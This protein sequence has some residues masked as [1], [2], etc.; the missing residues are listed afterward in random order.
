MSGVIFQR[1]LQSKNTEA[2]MNNQTEM[3][4]SIDAQS[5]IEKENTVVMDNPFGMASE[6]NS[7][8]EKVN[9]NYRHSAKPH[10]VLM[11][12]GD[13]VNVSEYQE[14]IISP[15]QAL[16]E[17][18]NTAL[19][20]N[21]TRLERNKDSDITGE[22]PLR[23]A[24]AAF[25]YNFHKLNVNPAFIVVGS[26]RSNILFK[27]LLL[28]KFQKP[29]KKKGLLQKV[30][31]DIME[32]GEIKPVVA[33]SEKLQSRVIDVFV[34]AGFEVVRIKTDSYGISIDE[35]KKSKATVAF[36]TTRDTAPGVDST[37]RQKE[38]IEWANEKSYRY[39][40]DYDLLTDFKDTKNIY[41]MRTK[42]NVIYLNSLSNLISKIINTTFIV[43][44]KSVLEEY[45]EKYKSFGSPLSILNQCAITDF[46]IKGKLTNY[47]ENL[48]EL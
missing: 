21:Q 14:K 45:K 12:S 16:I 10:E 39:I 44:P 9:A 22:A 7:E 4:D 33:V 41:K 37:N 32:K 31:D 23:I 19:F 2:I 15:T 42:D 34:A 13:V 29:S 40:F 36:L 20:E 30:E 35:L 26:N 38:I 17:S 48:D 28:D 27:L 46:L 25:L 3:I 18:Y 24:F 6:D 11:N 5:V 43:L 1:F 47:L 8:T